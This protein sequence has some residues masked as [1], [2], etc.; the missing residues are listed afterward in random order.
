MKLASGA[1]TGCL[2]IPLAAGASKAVHDSTVSGQENITLLEQII[3]VPDHPQVTMQK[4]ELP[5]RGRCRS[6]PPPRTGLWVCLGRRDG[7]SM[8]GQT[9]YY[10]QGQAWYEPPGLVHKITKN[11]NNHQRTLFLAVII[12]E[13]GK[14]A[15]LPIT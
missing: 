5:P 10:Q 4:V 13:E 11:P 9:S 7:H 15:K 14:P 8:E 2:F 6:A 12:G 1:V 3:T